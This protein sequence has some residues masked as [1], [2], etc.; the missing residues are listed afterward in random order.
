MCVCGEH[1]AVGTLCVCGEH[2]AVGTL[3]VCGEHHA[4]GTLCVCGE[5]HAVGTLTMGKSF[6]SRQR[7]E[8]IFQVLPQLIEI[9]LSSLKSR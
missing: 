1:H 6:C 5:H 9:Q 4:V 7:T 8:V 2:H 3:C